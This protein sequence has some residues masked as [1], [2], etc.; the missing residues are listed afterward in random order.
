MK[1]TIMI[2]DWLYFERLSVGLNWYTFRVFA[3]ER[4]WTKIW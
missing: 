2:V 4:L 3:V 1:M